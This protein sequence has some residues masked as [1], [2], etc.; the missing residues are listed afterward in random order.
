MHVRI[1]IIRVDAER[2]GGTRGGVHGRGG[3]RRLGDSLG[4]DWELL[5][6]GGAER[7]EERGCVGV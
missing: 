7:G 3:E 5:A 4:T 2:D 1:E 6:D